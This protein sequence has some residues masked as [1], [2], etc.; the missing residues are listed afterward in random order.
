MLCVPFGDTSVLIDFINHKSD[1]SLLLLG[2]LYSIILFTSNQYIGAETICMLSCNLDLKYIS[3][4]A[5]CS[6]KASEYILSYSSPAHTTL[7]CLL[8]FGKFNTDVVDIGSTLA[9][10]G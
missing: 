5:R 8:N 9:G 7:T 2:K 6:A 1:S 4:L 10:I 3:Y